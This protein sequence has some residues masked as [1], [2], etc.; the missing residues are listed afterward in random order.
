MS[1]K[2]NPAAVGAFVLGAIALIVAGIVVLGGANLFA[3]MQYFTV[4]FDGTVNGLQI[5][6]PVKMQ[7]VEVGEVTQ[8]RAIGD[9]ETFAIHT[10][11]V[12]FVDRTRY[13]RLGGSP[14]EVG[15]A[16]QLAEKGLRAR[17]ELQSFITGQLYVSLEVLPDSEARFVGKNPQHPE[18]PAVPTKLAELEKT[19]TGIASKLGNLP[20]EDTVDRLNSLLAHVDEFV[21]S[22]ELDAVVTNLNATLEEARGA[23]ADARTLVGNVDSKVDPFA[24]SA[25]TALDQAERALVSVD[26]AIKPGSAV[27]YQLSVTL[28]ELADAARSIRVLAEYLDRNPNSIVF[29][30]GSGD[31]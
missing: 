7:G 26:A 12:M 22:D 20:L 23:V 5:G 9:L 4:Y 6:S 24:D 28:Q 14:A 11:T 16:K 30:R 27:S 21:Q 18:I 29:G 13:V 17:L 31:R 10:E 3:D 8:I 19:L 15:N 1:K 2:A 25:I